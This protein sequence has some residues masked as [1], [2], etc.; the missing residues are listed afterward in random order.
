MEL[1]LRSLADFE[2]GGNDHAV[3]THGEVSRYQILPALW[4]QH[5]FGS[6]T[7]PVEARQVAIVIW[8]ARFLEFHRMNFR[9]PTNQEAYAL[10][11][12]PG[13]M[14]RGYAWLS[15][16][17]RERCERFNHLCRRGAEAGH[18]RLVPAGP[19]AAPTTLWAGGAH[20]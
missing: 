19:V 9:P 13:A 4:R 7:D 12:A 18:G 8:R 17:V 1:P 3:G 2:S 20:P 14:G 6:P 15:P 5:S 10:W 16:V 11:N